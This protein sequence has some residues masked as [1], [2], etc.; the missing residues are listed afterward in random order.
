MGN[1]NWLAIAVFAIFVIF[2]VRGYS[3]GFLRMAV[4]LAGLLLAVFVTTRL[5]PQMAGILSENKTVYDSV[6]GKALELFHNRNSEYNDKSREEQNKVIEDYE[7]PSLIISD[8]IVKNNE[9]AYKEL[10][11]QLFEQYIAKYVTLLVIRCGTFVALW[12]AS[13]AVIWVVMQVTGILSKLPVIHGLNKT[14]GL[15]TGGALALIIV[16]IF[17]FVLVMFFGNTAAGTLLSDIKENRALNFLYESDILFKL[18]L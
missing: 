12:I 6:Y 9:E 13:A 5:A 14:L 11:V 1:L 4:S 15:I 8:L 16:W 10:G 2:M 18:F 17:F 7:L 3:K